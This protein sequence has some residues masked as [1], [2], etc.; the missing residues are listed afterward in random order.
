MLLPKV[1][2]ASTTVTVVVTGIITLTFANVNT[3]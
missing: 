1:A 3:T 2:K